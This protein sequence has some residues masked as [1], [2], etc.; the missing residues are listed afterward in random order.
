MLRPFG[1][2]GP[3]EQPVITILQTQISTTIP[4]TDIV[5]TNKQS[6]TAVTQRSYKCAETTGY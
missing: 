2:F 3:I 4:Q 1:P 6:I 5:N